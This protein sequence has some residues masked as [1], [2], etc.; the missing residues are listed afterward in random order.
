MIDAPRSAVL[1]TVRLAGVPHVKQKPDFCGEACVEMAGAYF[2]KHFDQDRVFDLAGIDPALGRGAITP[3]LTRALARLGFDVGDV[4]HSIDAGSPGADLEA[5]FQA[6][7][8]DLLRGV[9]TIVCM[10][11]SSAP[12]TTEH[13]RLVVGY[14]Q[15]TDEVEYNEPA[16][17][18]GAYRRM[19]RS[20]LLSLW[21]L[22]YQE[23]RW[24][25]VRIPLVPKVLVEPPPKA[26]SP[27]PADVVQHVM[28]LKER[29]PPGFTVL[30]EPPFVV[31]GPGPRETL[32]ERG[33]GTV[34][35]A[36]DMLKK[37]FF[38]ASPNEILDVWLYPDARTYDS[39]VRKLT[40]D[41]PDTPYGFYSPANH[42]LFM[43][44]AT[45]GGTLVHEIVH[46]FVEADFPDAPSWLN[47]GL[48][49]LFEQSGERDGHIIGYTNWRLASL[50]KAIRKH[51]LPTFEAL[52]KTTSADFYDDPHGTNYAQSRYLL[53]YLQEKGALIPFYRDA[54][55]HRLQDP[56]GYKALVR[57]LG[58]SDMKAFQADWEQYVM[59]LTFP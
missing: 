28:A 37:D 39:G 24:T 35:W 34:R 44:F 21:P 16:E 54:R 56:T 47:E 13:F 32:G 41:I 50:Q 45:G 27:L 53:Y 20:E 22:K 55:A 17:D 12:H 43:N 14:E 5:Q 33:G 40:G 11:Y 2:G 52:A 8:R 59:A 46:P 57:A 19:K 3:D 7:H 36:R 29:M 58:A 26:E 49:S 9:P 6:M 1:S 15:T 38:D 23:T 31:L 42:G 18:H 10:H 48:G 4:W 51:A 25:V 30:L